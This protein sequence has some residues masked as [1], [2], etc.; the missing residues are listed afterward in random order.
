MTPYDMWDMWRG[1]SLCRRLQSRKLGFKRHRQNGV[2][3]H[4]MQSGHIVSKSRGLCS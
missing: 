2:L 3:E 1:A 4:L